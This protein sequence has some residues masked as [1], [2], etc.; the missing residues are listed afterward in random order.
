[1]HVANDYFETLGIKT[2]QGRLFSNDLKT[3]TANAII[4]NKA[5]V[6]EI[7]LVGDPIGQQIAS[8][9]PFA[10]REIVGIIDDLNFESLHSKIQP[11]MFLIYPGECN[12]LLIKV[13]PS[14]AEST[15]N[16]LQA[17]CNSFYPEQI[18]EFHFL[19]TKLDLL[20]QSDKNTF[21]LMGYF[22][23]LA[24]IIACMGLFGLALFMMRSRTKEIGIRKV[25]G[26]SI[27]HIL[28]S[29]TKDFTIWI[30]IAYI[31]ALPVAFYGINEWLQNFAYRIDIT[32]WP[33]ILTGALTLFIALITVG[34]QAI[35]AA[36]AN[37]I[38]SLK[39]E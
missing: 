26:A 14:N 35:K 11:T 38:K 29:L 39:Y 32:I 30:I 1:M 5:A 8:V 20:Y 37:P 4:L 9:W 13:S 17:I 3:D 18:F 21:R 22:T 31:I 24:V 15:I 33:F 27:I 2:V 23:A 19:D 12:R 16:R 7:G 36:S 25:L 10:K 6:K 34:Y 28:I